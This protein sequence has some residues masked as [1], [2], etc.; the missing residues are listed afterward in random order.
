MDIAAVK[1]DSAAVEAG[2]WVDEIPQMGDLRLRVRG[3]SSPVVIEARSAKERA[4]PAGDRHRD[5]SIKADVG[6][7]ITRQVIVEAV[8]LDW[9]NLCANGKKVKYSVEKAEEWILDPDFTPFADAV[10]W[11][12]SYVDR[13]RASMAEDVEKN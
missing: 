5:G 11:A 6:M 3:F 9:D 12:A 13:G 2:Q 10:A 7:Q 8:L 1:R 4:V